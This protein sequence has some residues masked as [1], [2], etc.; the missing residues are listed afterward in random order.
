MAK[1]VKQD[2]DLESTEMKSEIIEKTFVNQN[3]VEVKRKTTDILNF[4]FPGA[5]S[6]FDKKRKAEENGYEA[7]V[8]KNP[9]MDLSYTECYGCGKTGHKSRELCRE[10]LDKAEGDVRGGGDC[11]NSGKS[12]LYVHINCH[13]CGKVGHFSR[14][15][16]DKDLVEVKQES[17]LESTEIKSEITEKSLV[18]QD[19]IEAV[20]VKQE[21][22]HESVEIKSEIIEKSLANQDF[23]KVKQESKRSK[24][25][26]SM[27]QCNLC[28]KSFRTEGGR[29]DHMKTC[30]KYQCNI[31]GKVLRTKGGRKS[32]MK[33]CQK[34]SK[35]SKLESVEIKSEITEKAE[36]SLVHQDIVEVEQESKRSKQSKRAKGMYQCN[37][38]GKSFPT[39]GGRNDHMKTCQKCNICGKR[40]K[41]F[42]LESVEMYH[43]I[44]CGKSLCTEVG[45]NDHMRTCP[46]NLKI[47]KQKMK[48]LKKKQALLSK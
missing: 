15:C 26:E 44:I 47:I 1:K 46:E 9:K 32:H 33:T 43:C 6:T 19:F 42:K 28:G 22:D 48:K 27:Y 3:L 11:F 23:V 37:I 8:S 20:E 29:N 41:Q 30:Q 18:N 40:S 38:C 4:P 16:P 5:K 13:N 24:Q 2:F 12:G 39:E 21:S 14:E 25:L 36:E 35:Q 31:C 10:C 34:R 17:D 45:R 7:W